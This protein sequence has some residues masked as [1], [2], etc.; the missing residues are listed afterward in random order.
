MAVSQIINVIVNSKGAVTVKK[1]LD[2]IGNSAKTTTTYLNSMRAILAAA[3]TFSGAG[4]IVQT[5]D[6]FTQLQNRLK[7]VTSEAEGTGAAW[8]RLMGIANGSYSTIDNT[9]NLYYRVA[10]AFK[11]WG[12]SAGDA[13]G[14]V[15]KFQKAAILSGST[16][17][18]TSQAVYQF[19]QALNKGKLDG[20]EFRSVLEG[21]PYV[22]NL[23]QKS[24]GKTR[25]ELYE[26]SKDG[27]I[28]VDRI[29]QAFEEAAK[30]IESDW[31]KI[32]PTIGMAMNVLRNNWTDFVGSIQTSTGVFSLVA[33][34]ILLIANNFHVLAA[35]LTPVAAVMAFMAGR[36]VLGLLVNGFKD[37]YTVITRAIP[38]ITAFNALL[39]TNPFVLVAALI[40]A[41]VL[42]IVYFRNELGLTNEVLSALWEKVTAVFTSIVQFA[43]SIISPIVEVVKNF[44]DWRE[45]MNSLM[46]VVTQ[47]W[48]NIVAMFKSVANVVAQVA[49][50]IFGELKP[51]FVELWNLAKSLGELIIEIAKTHFKLLSEAIKAVLPIFKTVWEYVQPALVKF[52]GFLSDVLT[53]WKNI[54]NWLSQNFMPVVREV[55]EGWI[56]LIRGVIGFIEKL[57][58]ALKMALSLMHKVTAGSSGGG[59]GG[60]AGAN[61]GAQF[62]AGEFANGGGF[63]V[64][65]TGAGRDTTDVAFRANRGERVTVE[66]KKQQRVS[67]AAN[68]NA[69]PEVNVPVQVVNVLDPKMMVDAL[70]TDYAEK[71]IINVFKK[72]RDDIRAVLGVS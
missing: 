54:A 31:A 19:S 2:D 65:G 45:V 25:A 32:T 43:T 33:S 4:A 28:T 24:L 37:M 15:D 50:Y 69:V 71:Q 47:V 1:Q 22:A 51:V 64:G 49:S 29:K 68:Q 38:V 59:G 40:A 21:L 46:K 35:A 20:D 14:F 10:Q 30:T 52:I 55:F 3:M 39:W 34:A 26:M 18:T 36:L 7:L 72:N 53:G 6:S 27:K 41:V 16:M 63:K 67:D 66:T 9:V 70:D 11:S 42:A 57:I 48:N 58:A 5:I 12:E 44:V 13:Y 23:I 61:Y 62:Y 60:A 56:I 17:Q 8:N